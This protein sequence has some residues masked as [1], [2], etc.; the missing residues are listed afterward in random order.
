MSIVIGR[1][2][3]VAM[4]T[5]RILNVISVIYYVTVQL[6]PIIVTDTVA[7]HTDATVQRISAV[8]LCLCQLDSKPRNKETHRIYLRVQRS[9][10][11]LR[12]H[13]LLDSVGAS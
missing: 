8:L 4:T 3:V 2:A 5:P 11:R 9:N 10:A 12:G 1:A 7:R 13:V 6:V